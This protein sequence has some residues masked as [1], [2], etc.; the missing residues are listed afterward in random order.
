M[1][2]RRSA[3]GVGRGPLF[4]VN[5]CQSAEASGCWYLRSATE[6]TADPGEPNNLLGEQRGLDDRL[7]IGEDVQLLLEVAA[8]RLFSR[9]MASSPFCQHKIENI[10][11]VGLLGHLSPTRQVLSLRDIFALFSW[12]KPVGVTAFLPSTHISVGVA[13]SIASA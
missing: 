3:S 13:N 9:S 10:R 7:K 1:A 2:T 12:V 5:L 11:A 8:D 6:K 4:R